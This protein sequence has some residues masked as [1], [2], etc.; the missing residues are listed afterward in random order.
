MSDQGST[1]RAPRRSGGPDTSSRPDLVRE[2]AVEAGDDDATAIADAGTLDALVRRILTLLGRLT[3]LESTYLTAIDWAAG[4][5]EI[6][7]ARNDG[8][9]QIPEG[10][11]VEWCD[12]LCRRALEGG[13]SRTDDVPGIYPDSGAA[14]D[15]GIRTYITV[16]VRDGDG[17]PVGTLCGASTSAIALDDDVVLLMETLADMICLHRTS[18][19]GAAKLEQ[20]ALTDPL[21]LLA[22]RR[23]VVEQFER[24]CSHARRYGTAVSLLVVDVDHFKRTNDSYGHEI[25]D[26]VLVAVA[27]ALRATCRGDDIIGRWGGD[28]FVVVAPGL[29]DV[30]AVRMAER[31]RLA[32]P[33]RPWPASLSIGV[34]TAAG[35]QAVEL[36]TAADAALYEAKSNGRN[37]VHAVRVE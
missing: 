35:T 34:A 26:A 2:P 22:N 37:Q 25:G 18:E 10:L 30:G 16:P 29:D 15:L 14:R 27:D 12:T 1:S 7:Y 5:Q 36:F 23:H 21:T 8:V 19:A 33:W 9:L 6:L 11:R 32:A 20:L 31:I 28:E 17:E 3:G 4:T 13:P 24:A